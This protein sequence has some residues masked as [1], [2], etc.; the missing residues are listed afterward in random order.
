[1]SKKRNDIEK[2][3]ITTLNMLDK[4]GSNGEKYKKLFK[5]MTDTQ[6]SK[7]VMDESENLYLELIPMKTEPTLMEIEKA[8]KYINVPLMENVYVKHTLPDG[9]SVKLKH[10]APV[11]YL[12]L[13]KLQQMITKKSS[14][15]TS[16]DDRSMKFNQ[17]T[18]SDS[19][20]RLTE[21]EIFSI[22]ARGANNVLREL[23]GPRSDNSNKQEF[24]KHITAD[25]YVNLSQ[26]ENKVENHATLSV[27]SVYLLGMGINNDLLAPGYLITTKEAREKKKFMNYIAD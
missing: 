19:A 20:A 14:Y 9:K 8:A 21:P 1:M 12:H 11:G 10:K 24:Y 5:N 18:G 13:K 4:S 26:I 16:I 3:I 6:F 23:M 15:A 22:I 2:M 17:A 27:T 7:W 25:G